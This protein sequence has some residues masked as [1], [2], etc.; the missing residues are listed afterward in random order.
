MISKRALKVDSSGIRKVFELASKIENPINLS[1]GQP[2]FDVPENIKNAAID[3]IQK[4][5]NRYTLTQG[6]A[7]LR[8]KSLDYINKTRGSSFKPD[9]ILITSGVS[10][11]LM[12]ALMSII[13][14]GDEI[15]FFDPYFVMYK[16]LVNLLGGTPV[17]VD[18]YP[19]FKIDKQKLEAAITDKTKA[20]IINSPSNPTGYVYTQEDINNAVSA[21][22]SRNLLL[23][24]DEIY[25]GFV[26]DGG[27]HSPSEIYDNTLV[28]GGFS[29]TYA[30]TGWRM[31]YAAGNAD[32]IAQMIKIQQYSFVCAPSPFQYASLEALNTDMSEFKEAYKKKRD[33]V[34]NGLKDNFD[35]IKPN[36]AFYIFPRLKSGNVSEFVEK[37]IANRVLI[38]PGNVFS[39]KNTNFRISFASKDN[40]LEKGVEILNKLANEF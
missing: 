6:I 39:E 33:I 9:Q 36:G 25:D 38:I 12:L 2:D 1:I 4:G 14:P 24:S 29:K 3:A 17:I 21:A 23:I 16:H 11:G 37:A 30:M 5:F 13:D 20:I 40:D 34:Y 10:G 22:K 32:I 28:L 7:E 31:G 8:E 19:D 35:I 18:S 15:I 27:F 26:Y